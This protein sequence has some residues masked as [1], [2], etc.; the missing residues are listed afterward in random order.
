MKLQNS[1][2]EPDYQYGD[3]V[4]SQTT[5]VTQPAPGQQAGP[6]GATREPAHAP[7][8]PAHAQANSPNQPTPTRNSPFA[9]TARVLPAL[10]SLRRFTHTPTVLMMLAFAATSAL[11][12]TVAA[13]TFAVFAWDTSDEVVGSYRL[14]AALATT[15]LVV[16]AFTLG[17][18]A[19]TLATRR[20]DEQLSTLALLGAPRSTIVAAALTEPLVAAAVGAL[21]G[22]VGYFALALP[23]S[24]VQLRGEPL[25]YGNMIL[26]WWMILAT[27]VALVGVST[28]AALMGL[29]KVVVSPLG[30]RTKA[31]SSSFPW[32]RI[33]ACFVLLVCVAVGMALSQ[34][35]SGMAIVLTGFFGMVLTGLLVV[36]VLGVLVVRLVARIRRGSKKVHVMVA[37]RLVSAK[38]KSYWR[39]VSGLALTSF[40]ATFCGTGVALTQAVKTSDGVELSPEDILL[41]TDTFTGILLTLG[42][43]FVFITVSAVI[44]QAADIYDRASTFQELN[45]AGMDDG[46]IRKISVASVMLPVVWISA[47]SAG[48]GLLL[49][50]PFAG[51]AVV[52]SPLSFLTI[53]S[54]VLVGALVVRAGLAITNPLI[55]KVI[56]RS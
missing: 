38:P 10:F 37:S 51:A 50:L 52:L 32:G 5:S 17:Q 33:V 28:V 18:S 4:Y 23:V 54:M 42:I 48:L 40:I 49:V 15:L 30:V 29:R 11:L 12:L 14:L 34:M 1:Y 35:A 56:A 8:P 39:R 25:G 27:V 16:P 46:T 24:L 6:A 21:A 20:Q 41:T 13:G 55:A 19:A 45:A 3:H 31:L 7:T 2:A 43:S 26:P 22:V 47:I 9:L 36:D 44:N 53:I